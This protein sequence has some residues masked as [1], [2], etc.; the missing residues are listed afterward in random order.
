MQ[1]QYTFNCKPTDIYIQIDSWLYSN[2]LKNIVKAF[3]GTFPKTSNRYE[4][5]KWLLKFSECWDYRNHQKQARDKKTGENARWQISSSKITEAQK[6]AVINGIY[7]LGLIG[8]HRPSKTDFDYIVALGGARFSCLYRPRYMY[9][10]ITEYGITAK[11][12]VLLSG[13]RPISESE[14]LATD[15]YAPNAATEYDLINAGGEQS[16]EL[17]ANY[18]EEIYHHENPNKSW[19]VRTYDTPANVLPLFSL[20]GP[21]S[22]PEKRRANSADTYQ[23]FLEKFNVKSGQK[24]LLIT[25]QIYVPYQQIE[26]LRTLAVPNGLYIETV[27]FPVEW[28]NQLQGMMEPAN[29]LQEIRSTIQAINRYLDAVKI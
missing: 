25:S 23:F 1:N 7:A 16:F 17:P 2:E 27:G 28:S 22:D 18:R 24:L 15:T 6:S 29:Y 21:S 5:A 8:I 26:A 20:S 3:G 4:T 11:A 13:M 14:R 19:A 10:L 12:A 9:K